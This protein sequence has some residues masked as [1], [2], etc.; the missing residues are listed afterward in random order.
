MTTNPNRRTFR[1]ML[2][3]GLLAV[4]VGLV[5]SVIA[6]IIIG[7][8]LPEAHEVTR[9]TT[10]P[11]N[12]EEVWGVISDFPNQPKWRP[13]VKSVTNVSTAEREIWREDAGG[14]PID[15]RTLQ[16]EAP[17]TFVRAIVGDNLP[18]SGRWEFTLKPVDGKCQVTIVERGEV[19]NPLFRFV[20][21]FVFGYATSAETYLNDLARKFAAPPPFP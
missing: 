11:A 15:F 18:F 6:M 14:D 9:S 17:H 12:P 4:V 7:H 3:W 2:L 19:T 13:S 1:M 20:A 21:R 8:F 10:I 5:L 16:A